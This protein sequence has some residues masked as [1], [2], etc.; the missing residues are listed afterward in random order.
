MT[1]C[2]Y[3]QSVQVPANSFSLFA[4][5]ITP[6]RTRLRPEYY[7][8]TVPEYVRLHGCP[9]TPASGCLSDSCLRNCSVL[10][11]ITSRG[12]S[13]RGLGGGISSPQMGHLMDTGLWCLSSVKGRPVV[14]DMDSNSGY[15]GRN[16]TYC[17]SNTQQ[18]SG[19]HVSHD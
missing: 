1:P 10:H 9:G 14:V 11:K 3:T 18:N 16:I 17:L 8:N 5:R 13:K 15:S 12:A 7:I 6:V 4:A 19:N 2:A